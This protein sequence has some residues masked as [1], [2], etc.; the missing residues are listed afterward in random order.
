MA[1]LS[2]ALEEADESALWMEFIIAD[3]LLTVEKVKP[4]LN[5]ANEITKILA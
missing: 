5:E 2:I 3:K 1:N 4:I